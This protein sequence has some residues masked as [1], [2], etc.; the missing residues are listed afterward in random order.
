[1][2]DIQNIQSQPRDIMHYES[3][4][5]AIADLLLAASVKQSD[6]PAYMMPFFA[7]MMLEGRMLNAMKR[8]EEEEG[9]TVEDNP[10]DFK[11]AFIDRDCGY[12]EYIVMQ[13]KTL[14]NI[15]NN[16]KTF[17]QDFASYLSEFDPTLKKLLGI[18]RG[19]DEKKFLN[20]DYYVAELRSKKILLSV[21]TAW[22]K[23]DLSPYDN[24][25]ITTLEEH[26]KRKWADISA[27]TAGE[28][29]TPDDIISLIA[30]I[31]ATKVTKPKNQNI[32][33]YDPTCGGANLL[34]GVADRLHTQAGYQNI[35]TW[36]S[37]YN[38]ALYALAAI[39]SR[40]RSH[41]KIS[42]GNT[43]TTAPF[44]DRSFD[45]IVANPP[46][47]TKWSGYEKAIKNDQKGQ[48]PG[49][50]PSVSDGQLL[51]MQH[52]LWQLDSNGI[53]FEVH[54]GSTLF[55]GD[56]GSGESNI[57]KYI[58]DH[59]W[60]EAIIQMPQ[61]EFFN[62]GIY[63]YLWIMNKQ[64]P[65][66]RKNKVALIDGS[67]LWKP[68]KKSKG[69]KR[70]EM[71]F[72]HREAIVKALTDFVPSDICKIF[73]R[74]HFYYNKQSLTLT[75]ISEEGHYVEQTVC[76]DGK[77][78]VIKKPASLTIGEDVYDDLSLLTPDDIKAIAKR[79]TSE[80]QELAVS[81]ITEDDDTYAFL[82]EK[83][84]IIH[85]DKDGKERDLGCGAFSFKASVNKKQVVIHKIAIEPFHTSDYE[86]IPHHF[87]EHENQ[88][89]VEAFL[90]KYVFKPYVLGKNVVGV[91]LN[92]NKEL[93]VPEE[94]SDI[95]EI[96]KEI[97]RISDKLETLVYS[98][99]E[100][101]N[102]VIKKGL[103]HK[104][105]FKDTEIDGIGLIPTHW[106]VRRLK[107]IGTVSSGMTP[108]TKKEAY[109]SKGTH[110]W[111]NT[112]CVQ[113]CEI[114]TPADYVTDLA[115]KECKG[116]VYYPVDTILIAMYGGGTI[117]NVGIMRIPATINQ[118]CCALSLNKR[119]VIPK[120]VFYSLYAKKKWI[121]SRGFGGTQVNLSQG[122]IAN[123]SIE[124]PPIEE[125]ISIVNYLDEEFSKIEVA[126]KDITAQIDSLK[127]LR[128]TLAK[129]I[130]SGQLFIK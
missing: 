33:V 46:Y 116:L 82:P 44:M 129:D 93:Y 115:L 37:E 79:V 7:L 103:D 30:D 36:G 40:F 122:Q 113:D 107:E 15:C 12:N 6:F 112:G 117:G 94:K 58:F 84:T 106:K 77:A 86:I 119:V 1:M 124:I 66:E 74:E 3:D 126:I 97:K 5:W 22:S 50:L 62:T 111:L 65:F 127:L 81:V 83:C 39:E 75:E 64:K 61:S 95:I 49:G 16:D 47:G 43:L 20:M 85:T 17:E 25:A 90:Q 121:I 130:I 56:A 48:F 80:R 128:T 26:I 104:V 105:S 114:Y 28:Q 32:H 35:H 57:R 52:I 76:P 92:F 55:S 34:F 88:R 8:V 110:P 68:L 9:L 78:F 67:N 24:S 42:Y 45:V 73:D 10:E 108:N 70:R 11:E 14:Q 123:F 41:S 54:N 60:V 21:I 19:K 69:D 53:A 18:E 71:T 87:N 63:T 2:T 29:Y 98:K 38:D 31:V 125:Q 72:E 91:E 51:F 109:Y 89:E 23:I 120:Y 99:F 102:T 59:D 27:S 96:T 100:L 4:I 101:L 118:A 13:G